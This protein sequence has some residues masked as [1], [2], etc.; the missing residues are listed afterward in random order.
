MEDEAD[1]FEDAVS[2]SS[3][4]SESAQKKGKPYISLSHCTVYHSIQDIQSQQSNTEENQM[5]A[6]MHQ[7]VGSNSESHE[8][9]VNSDVCCCCRSM[10]NYISS[11]VS[12]V[13]CCVRFCIS[14]AF[15]SLNV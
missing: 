4:S 9:M 10:I 2:V 12:G 14:T 13:E 8:N 3:I 11:C 1:L 6:T 15:I 7:P 5:V